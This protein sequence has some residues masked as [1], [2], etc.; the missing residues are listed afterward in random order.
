MPWKSSLSCF[1]YICGQ[2]KLP[3]VVTASTCW[4]AVLAS[5]LT[6]VRPYVL[7]PHDI[8]GLLARGV[9]VSRGS[10]GTE[11]QGHDGSR[12]KLHNRQESTIAKATTM[13]DNLQFPSFCLI[14]ARLGSWVD[15]RC[16]LSSI[17]TIRHGARNP[18]DTD[19]GMVRPGSTFPG[20]AQT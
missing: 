11:A 15:S 8:S 1:R 2:R 12:A 9:P 10:M 16:Y 7:R 4:R 5:D 14:C 6:S 20:D 18:Q 19:D 3:A 13:G 17:L